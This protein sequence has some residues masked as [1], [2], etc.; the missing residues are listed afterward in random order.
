MGRRFIVTGFTIGALAAIVALVGSGCGVNQRRV[1][2]KR[3][4][5]KGLSSP[6]WNIQSAPAI[7][8]PSS[9]APPATS[10]AEP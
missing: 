7:V 4:A 9:A 6:D 1:V 5:V 2:V 10:D 3:E 8:A